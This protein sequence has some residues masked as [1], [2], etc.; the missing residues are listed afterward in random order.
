MI[1][2]GTLTRAAIAMVIATAVAVVA[3]PA[4]A[5]TAGP[6][7]PHRLPRGDFET[8]WRQVDGK[9]V[10]Q[11]TRTTLQGC[12]Y[13][14]EDACG[15]PAGGPYVD[16][17]EVSYNAYG[18]VRA[19]IRIRCVV[20]K[21]GTGLPGRAALEARFTSGRYVL[22][23]S[24]RT[25]NVDLTVTGDR[26]SGYSD[27]S[28]PGEGRDPIVDGRIRGRSIFFR[29]LCG[30]RTSC[31]QRFRGTLIGDRA[32]GL[33]TGAGARRPVSWTLEHR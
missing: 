29:I 6:V 19:P 11:I 20:Q 17:A 15:E 3:V 21:A 4:V 27:R 32:S 2:R 26:F 28:T 14:A 10:S 18:C 25:M 33:R 12:A 1:G 24:N 30:A 5:Q 23:T 16:G 7:T 22:K 8:Y 31:V 13:P 9:W